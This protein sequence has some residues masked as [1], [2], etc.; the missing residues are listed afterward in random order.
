MYWYKYSDPQYWY[1]GIR[2]HKRSFH[3]ITGSPIIAASH[4]VKAWLGF[5]DYA[6]RYSLRTYM[7]NLVA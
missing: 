2:D 7:P 1:D 3:I 4:A 5:S 6:Q